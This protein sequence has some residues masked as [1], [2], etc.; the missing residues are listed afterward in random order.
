MRVKIVFAE[1]YVQLLSF[2]TVLSLAI[3]QGSVRTYVRW[4]G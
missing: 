4:S 1:S 3:L 2:V